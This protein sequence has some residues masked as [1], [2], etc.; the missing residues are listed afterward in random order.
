M[1]SIKILAGAALLGLTSF[2]GTAAAG[3]ID[4]HIGVGAPL[5]YDPGYREYHHYYHE[6]RRVYHYY[7]HYE[8]P[9]HHHYDHRP[10]Y[11]FYYRD[12]DRHHDHHSHRSHHGHW[13]GHHGHHGRGH[14]RGHH[15]D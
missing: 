10:V 4:L 1:K 2:A 8:R 15:D 3:D 12:R 6:P 7:D 9:V 14:H 5:Y 11:N 13:R